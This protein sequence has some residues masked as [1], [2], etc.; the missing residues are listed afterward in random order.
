VNSGDL[1]VAV[2]SDGL[3]VTMPGTRY[4]VTFRLRKDPIF[5]CDFTLDAHGAPIPPAE[6]LDHAWEVA[7]AKAQE[8]G[9]IG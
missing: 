2:E 9:W 5:W 4:A 7:K 1:H 6:F 3:R 8:L